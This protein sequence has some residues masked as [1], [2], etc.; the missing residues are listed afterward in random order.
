MKP[1]YYNV[2]INITIVIDVFRAFTTASYVLNAYPSSYILTNKSDVI[3]QLANDYKNPLFIGKPEIGSNFKYDIPNSPTRVKD[4]NITD[5][6]ILHRTEAGAKGLLMA[7][8]SDI[9]LAAS[10]VNA[11]ATVNY[12]KKLDNTNIEIMPMGHEATTPSLE[13]DVCASYIKALINNEKFDLN[14]HKEEIKE[15]P[16]K[17]FFSSD[18]WQ[19]PYDDFDLCLELDKFDFAIKAEVHDDY[20]V[21]TRC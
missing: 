1:S 9:V 10:F 19:Y 14:L 8:D 12:I 20:S 11:N 15:G 5:Q 4:I 21:L 7:K 16:G 13:D 2:N 3:L 17:Y 6:N 18:Q